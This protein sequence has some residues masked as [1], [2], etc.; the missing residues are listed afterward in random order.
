MKEDIRT[1]KSRISSTGTRPTVPLQN[2]FSRKETMGKFFF[3]LVCSGWLALHSGVSE[4]QVGFSLIHIFLSTELSFPGFS[5]STNRCECVSAWRRRRFQHSI[6][7][8]RDSFHFHFAFNTYS[9]TKHRTNANCLLRVPPP[10]P[11]AVSFIAAAATGCCFVS[12]PR[13]GRR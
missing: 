7:R 2:Y 9:F 13:S 12:G 8:R 3:L 1:A 11:P 4:K 6:G 5:S 10:P